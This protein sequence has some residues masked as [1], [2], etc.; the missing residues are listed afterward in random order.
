MVDIELLSKL[1]GAFGV[2]SEEGEI[3][4]IMSDEFRRIGYKV[5]M[6]RMGNVIA[7]SPKCGNNPLM[8][9][10]HMDEIGLMVKFV[11][12]Q[13]FIRFVKLGGIDNR[14]LLNQRVVIQAE[15]K[16]IYGVIGNKPP[17]MQ[18]AEEMKEAVD[19]K[20]LFIDIGAKNKKDALKMGI[21]IGQ[22]ICFDLDL[23]VLNERVVTGKALDDRVG[24]YAIIEAA[25]KLKGKDIVFVGTAQEEVSTFGKGAA[26]AAYN[27]QP[28]AFIA[29]DTS[30]AGDHPEMSEDETLVH[31]NKGPALVLVEAGGHGNVADRK[32][33]DDV[34]KIARGAKIAC[35]IEVIEG[36]ST[37]AAS[38]Y[39]VRGGIPSIAIGVPSRYIHSNVSICG[40]DDIDA[41]VKLVEKLGMEL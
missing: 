22:P 14:V 37:D 9:G 6:D 40:L 23:K 19:N 13:G 17:H 26:I 30:I 12:D 35:Q 5:Q 28:R 27:L 18:K 33:R 15:G 1:A 8:I 2:P 20:K 3:A 29:V 31:I 41:T 39:N 24:C 10:A 4:R 38:V 32:L 16:K 7:R 21:K 34:L 25:R 36:G 11:N